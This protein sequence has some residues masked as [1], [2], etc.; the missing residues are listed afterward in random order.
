MSDPSSSLRDELLPL[1][2]RR[3]RVGAMLIG[4]SIVLYALLEL[5]Q[6]RAPLA[7]FVFVKV[8]QVATLGAVWLALDRP[9][10]W[11]RSI[12]VA[13]VLVT[14]VC[15]T[16]AIS[17]VLTGE[18]ASAPL[19]CVLVTLG[20]ATLLPWGL[21]PQAVTVTVAATSLAGNAL[22]VPVPDGFGYT[23]TAASMACLAS[24]YVAHELEQQRSHRHHAEDE[25][26][27]SASAL[28]DEIAVAES[29]AEAAREL[30]AGGGVTHV[31]GTLCRLE[32]RLLGCDATYTFLRDAHD[33]KSF[34]VVA[35]NGDDGSSWT[36]RRA[37][38]I[39]DI[40]LAR[41]IDRLGR[42]QPVV[43]AGERDMLPVD[44]TVCIYT[45]LMAGRDVAG[46]QVAVRREA[47]PFAPSDVE[48]ARRLTHTASA[49]LA[50]ARLAEAR[51]PRDGARPSEL[52]ERVWQELQTPLGSIL[53]LAE[54]AADLSLPAVERRALLIRVAS[55]T[56][57]VLHMLERLDRASTPPGGRSARG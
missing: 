2:I 37:L 28:R 51:E 42:D 44:G 32:A 30:L 56:R 27:K 39:P 3:I 18:V 40:V 43:I 47:R 55:T 11:R 7:P 21:G 50:E 35:S 4:V 34:A 41:M 13:L 46:I 33:A 20:T 19:L 36:S 49:A 14:E 17:G 5:W 10:S 38:R 25:E 52:G 54:H 24:L 6:Q 15:V 29:S 31:L 23:V 1:L 8:V 26:R 57:D 53:R 16:L 12:A 45:A 9:G 22:W 48:L